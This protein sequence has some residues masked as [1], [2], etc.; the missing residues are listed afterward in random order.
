MYV[1]IYAQKY[2]NISGIVYKLLIYLSPQ[3]LTNL[4][5]FQQVIACL[6]IL[7]KCTVQG[8]EGS[9]TDFLSGLSLPKAMQ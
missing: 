8:S 5:N 7:N 6:Y 9:R 3:V 2:V 4:I 1:C